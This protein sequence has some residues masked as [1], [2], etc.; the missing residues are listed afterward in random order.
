[1]NTVQ[2]RF[3]GIQFS[4]NPRIPSFELYTLLEPIPGHCLYS[5]VS[6]RTIREAGYTPVPRKEADPWP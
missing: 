5:T 2:V 4:E 1:M 6:V 3:V